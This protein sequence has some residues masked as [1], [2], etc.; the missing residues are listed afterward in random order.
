MR[1]APVLFLSALFA[2]SVLCEKSRM[3]PGKKPPVLLP[4]LR[5]LP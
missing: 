3:L 4:E 5:R 1:R 2:T